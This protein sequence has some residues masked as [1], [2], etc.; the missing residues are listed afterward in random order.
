ML[1]DQLRTSDPRPNALLLCGSVSTASKT[2]ALLKELE[3]LLLPE[4]S[5]VFWDL[6]TSPLPMADPRYHH[7]PSDVP[8]PL[9]RAF[10]QAIELADVVALASPLY[11]GSYS[12]VIKNALDHL[13]YDAFRDKPVALLSHGANAT[14]C[15]QPAEHLQ[16][17]VRTMYGINM[18]TQVCTSKTDYSVDGDHVALTSGDVRNRLL[19]LRDELRQFSGHEG[20]SHGVVGR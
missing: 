19:R 15:A 9:A 10:V 18:Q 6:A 16:S 12:G 14:R 3:S 5:V 4:M 8:E 7:Q 20:R 17:V 2:R 11:H 13:G 1:P